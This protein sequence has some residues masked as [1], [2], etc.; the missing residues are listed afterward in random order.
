[1]GWSLAERALEAACHVAEHAEVFVS[2]SRST[3]VRFEAN[4]LKEVHTI[5]GGSIALRLV[6]D[7]RMGVAVAE[8]LGNADSEAVQATV[9]RLADMAVET[10]LVGNKAR[11][12]F[13]PPA[14]YPDVGLYDRRVPDLHT[15]KMVDLGQE[16]IDR[17]TQHTPEVVCEA[18]VARTTRTTQIFNSAG[19]EARCE[20]TVFGIG[21]EG[22]FVRGTDMLFVGD[23]ETSCQIQQDPSEVASRVIEQLEL[24]SK[25]AVVETGRMQVLFTPQAVAGVLLPSL[26]LPL[27]GKVVVEGSSPLESRR[28]ELVFHPSLTLKDDPTVPYRPR[29]AP[30]DDEGVASR[31]LSLIDGG[32]VRGFLYDLASA[33]VAGTQSTGHGRRASSIGRTRPAP[34][35]LLVEPGTASFSDLVR[36]MDHGLVVEQLIGAGQGNLFGGDFGGNVLLGYKVERGEIVGRVKDTMV[37]GNIY[38]ALKDDLVVGGEARWVNGSVHTPHLLCS[39][40][41]VSAR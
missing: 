38:T 21:L 26:A 36:G 17:V 6:K 28:D 39:H 7:G 8:G 2:T 9:R 16:L 13:P 11:F 1:M 10:S 33:A 4:R 23:G 41:T 20:K 29:S 5:E 31:R 35:C 3:P 14:D 22:V 24:A 37:H 25:S 12:S 18:E 19:A 15:E 40:V 27:N 34:S 32:V 30:F